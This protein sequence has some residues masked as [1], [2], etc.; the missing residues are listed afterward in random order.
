MDPMNGDKAAPEDLPTGACRLEWASPPMKPFRSLLLQTVRVQLEGLSIL[1]LRLHRHLPE[2]DALERH[3]HGFSQLLCYLSGRGTLIAG[4]NATEIVSGSVAFIPA[5][6]IH[7]FKEQKGHR[8]L[9]Q[10]IDLQLRPQPAGTIAQLNHSEASKIRHHLSELSRLKAPDSMES[11]LLSASATLNIID[12]QFR[13]LGFLPRQ[14]A[15]VPAFIRKFQ[16]LAA[17]PASAGVPVLELASRMGYQADYLNRRFKQATG[18][19]LRQQRD[20]SRLERCKSGLLQGLPVGRV[21]EE[22]GFTDANY[23]SRWFK[24]HAGMSPSRFARKK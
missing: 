18:L 22:N 10:A 20:S 13:A 8:P 16:T 12:V 24:R 6:T 17:N 14:A 5:E 19:T 2:V 4:E 3:A 21:A 11:R 23:F 15:P 9:C 7:A 1:R